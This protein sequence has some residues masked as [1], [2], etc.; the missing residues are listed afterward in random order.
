MQKGDLD[1][2]FCITKSKTRLFHNRKHPESM[3]NVKVRAFLDH[4]AISRNVSIITQKTALNFSVL[5]RQCL[6]RRLP[7]MQT[8][9]TGIAAWMADRNQKTWSADWRFTT[10]GARIKLNQLYPKLYN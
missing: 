2:P 6:A 4:L 1:V 5:G 3:G 10:E 8:V 7:D 9:A